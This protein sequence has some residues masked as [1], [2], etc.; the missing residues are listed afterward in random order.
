MFVWLYHQLRL[1]NTG[2]GGLP[3]TLAAYE[4]TIDR[5]FS[6]GT[7]EDILIALDKEA[8]AGKSN[9]E[10]AKEQ[11]TI[12]RG[13]SALNTKVALKQIRMGRELSLAQCLKMEWALNRNFLVRRNFLL[14]S[15]MSSALNVW[16]SI[17][18]GRKVANLG[19]LTG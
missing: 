12:I 4:E 15:L 16:C 9:A 1:I 7:V 5:C 3:F 19:C 13:K 14:F 11:A 2:E 8:A 10:F 6:H 18:I 17:C